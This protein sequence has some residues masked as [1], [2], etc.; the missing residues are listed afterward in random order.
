M[1]CLTTR[2]TAGHAV[3]EL[4]RLIREGYCVANVDESDAVVCTDT[5]ESGIFKTHHKQT[6]RRRTT[7]RVHLKKGPVAQNGVPVVTPPGS[8]LCIN[9]ACWSDA[10]ASVFTKWIDL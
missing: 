1:V 7:I 8:Q 10:P 2:Y 4:E 9:D 6:E 5:Y 3:H